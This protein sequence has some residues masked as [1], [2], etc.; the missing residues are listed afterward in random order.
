MPNFKGRCTNRGS[1]SEGSMKAAVANV[2]SGKMSV[3]TAAEKC[4]G[5]KSSLQ[6]CVSLNIKGNKCKLLPKLGRFEAT[7]SVTLEH[8]LIEHV[9]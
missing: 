3:R 4:C 2:L 9:K 6:D 7:F 8:Q 5:P 1:W